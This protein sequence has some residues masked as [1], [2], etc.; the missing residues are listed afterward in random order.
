MIRIKK[1]K[2][3]IITL[4]KTLM[5]GQIHSPKKTDALCEWLN[6]LWTGQALVPVRFERKYEIA[7]YYKKPEVVSE[8]EPKD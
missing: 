3:S 7:E 2:F 1:T 5:D 4:P 8:E 6:K